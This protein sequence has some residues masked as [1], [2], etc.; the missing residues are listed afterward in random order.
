LEIEM[1]GN[2][3]MSALT[4]APIVIAFRAAARGGPA[5]GDVSPGA[6]GASRRVVAVRD[7]HQRWST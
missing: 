1:S 4:T 3:W 6:P 5:S 2:S 7:G